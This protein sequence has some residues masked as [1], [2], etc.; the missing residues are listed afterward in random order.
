MLI[1]LAMI[2]HEQD[3]RKFERLY[4]DYRQTMYYA[5]NRILQDRHLA[6]DAV[7]QAFLRLVD[8]LDMVNEENVYQ[9]KAFLTV[10]TEHIAIDLY[11]KRKREKWTSYEDMELYLTSEEPFPQEN[12]VLDAIFSLPVNYAKV[13]QLR[14]ARDCTI[15]EMAELLKISPENVR[16]RI[17]R[18]KKK[19]QE[20]LEEKGYFE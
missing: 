5:A 9:T 8:R 17:S 13:L 3:K 2:E 7:H 10:I 11:R 6:E 4:E 15:E 14:Y 20:I 18:A 19:L 1:Y 16:Q 12:E